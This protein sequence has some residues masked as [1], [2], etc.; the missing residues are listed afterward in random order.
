MRKKY[1]YYLN[2]SNRLI[3]YLD[4]NSIKY[5]VIDYGKEYGE[6]VI[7]KI[8][9]DE[10]YKKDMIRFSLFQPYFS[11]EYSQKELDEAEFLS[12]LPT[13]DNVD[14]NNDED[15]FHYYGCKYDSKKKIHFWQNA[16][17]YRSQLK[18]LIIHKFSSWGR[19]M[20]YNSDD[21]SNIFFVR[22]SFEKFVKENN[23]TGIE[24]WPVYVRKNKELKDSG[25][26]QLRSTDIIPFEKIIVDDKK[27]LK[28]CCICGKK[29]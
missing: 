1:S 15:L 12:I 16:C 2:H 23:L 13:K 3:N 22:K 25:L 5:E 10:P 18:P 4:K 17:A 11:M 26:Y 21:G 29:R 8:Y 24:L 14:I 27:K 7:F 9:D 20:F 19:A 28:S 6:K